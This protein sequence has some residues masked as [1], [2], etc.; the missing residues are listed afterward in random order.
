MVTRAK[1]GVGFFRTVFY[2]PALIPP[3]AATLG[4]VYILNPATGPINTL[5]G[6]L[7]IQGPLWFNDPG[8]SKPSL[9]LLAMWGV[10]QHHDHLPRRDPR[11]PSSPLRVGRA[12]RRGAVP[13]APLGDAADDQPRDPVRGR[14]RGDLRAPVLHAGMGR[15]RHR[16]RERVTGGRD[17]LARARLPARA[18]RSSTRSSSTTTDSST[19]TW[20]TRPRSRSCCSAVS[21][22]RD[23]ADRPSTRGAGSTTA[24][25]F[26]DGGGG[27]DCSG[28]P[29]PG[30]G[31]GAAAALPGRGR[32]SQRS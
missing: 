18:R 15:C 13:E 24:G 9:V 5:L 28:R 1:A 2:L 21:F 23:A 32:R 29:A 19:S 8:W 7:G 3:V 14:P 25:R 22:A 11:G 27:R 30:A 16:R 12:R 31:G 17:Q 10:G 20:A 4:F 26:A 6:H